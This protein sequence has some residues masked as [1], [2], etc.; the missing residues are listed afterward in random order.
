MEQLLTI[1]QFA[2]AMNITASCARRWV[3]ERKIAKVKLG[4]LVRIPASECERLVDEG[5]R[6][7][8]SVNQR[9]SSWPAE[10]A[11]TVGQVKP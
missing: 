1:Q 3:L 7:A 9:P 8:T 4:R 11:K 5:T 2:E 6:P 10:P